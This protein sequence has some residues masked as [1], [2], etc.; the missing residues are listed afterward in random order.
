M[1]ASKSSSRGFTLIELMTALAL[2]LLVTGAAVKL[3]STGVD[4]TWV[5]SQ[6]AEMQQDLRAAETMLLKDI[7]LAGAGLTQISGESIP[8]PNS[9][10]NPIYGCSAGP[11]CPPNGSIVYPSISGGPPTLYP[12]MPGYQKG[13]T[14]PGAVNPSDIITIVYSDTTLALNCYSGTANPITFN[15]TGNQLTFEAPA[16]PPPSGCVLPA[17]L[18]YPQALNNSVNGLQPGDLIM[19]GP[20]ANGSLIGVG[21][22]TAISGPAGAP[23]PCT[24][25]PTCTGGSSYV[26]TFANGDTLNINQAGATNDLT[27]TKTST[28]GVPVTRIYVITYYLK[29][30]T[31]AAGSTTTILYRQVNGQPA[32]PLVDNIANMQFTY[33]SYNSDGTLLNASGDGGESGGTSPN[34]IRKVN[35]AHLTI[36]GQLYGIKSSLMATQGFQSFDVQTSIS[37][38]NM[39]YSNRY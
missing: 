6:R 10:G 28:A 23:T 14:P 1:G 29:N 27:G 8:L 20:S 13:I 7:S 34:L 35:I 15:S 32:V 31:D 17:G 9:S 19:V 37:A 25:S 16:N 38:R 30:W 18:T 24:G 5:I 21:E 22:V 33:D 2:G 26:V 3:Y 4:A 12:L 36:H 39:S 11:V